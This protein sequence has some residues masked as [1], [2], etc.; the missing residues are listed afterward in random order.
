MDIPNH[1]KFDAKE[2]VLAF[3]KQFSFAR[4]LI[5]RKENPLP[6]NYHL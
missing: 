2:D 5:L 6:H 4:L 1:F 3:I